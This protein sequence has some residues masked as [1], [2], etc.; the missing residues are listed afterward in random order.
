M[1]L[2]IHLSQITFQ[3]LLLRLHLI[4]LPHSTLINDSML[5]FD[6]DFYYT[7]K[8]VFDVITMVHKNIFHGEM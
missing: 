5:H 1:L 2:V 8:W 6:R 4:S 3:P 7:L